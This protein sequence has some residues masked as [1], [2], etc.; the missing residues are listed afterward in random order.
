MWVWPWSSRPSSLPAGVALVIMPELPA[1]RCGPDQHARAHCLRV[2]PWSSCPSSLPVGVALVMLNPHCPRVQCQPTQDQAPP[3]EQHVDSA[4]LSLSG[5]SK[6]SSGIVELQKKVNRR[7]K[8]LLQHTRLCSTFCRSEA[9]MAC[10]ST[11]EASMAC[12]STS[13]GPIMY[14]KRE[15]KGRIYIT[16]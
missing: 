8:L 11:S 4:D 5:T 7:E 1:C 15:D 16:T 13:L 12:N 3:S 2:W 14:S 6:T 10:I 9:S